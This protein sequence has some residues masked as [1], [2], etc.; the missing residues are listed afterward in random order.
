M[1]INYVP[2][3]QQSIDN[4]LKVKTKLSILEIFIRIT[5]A[6]KYF[7]IYS[8]FGWCLLNAAYNRKLFAHADSVRIESHQNVWCLTRP[9]TMYAFLK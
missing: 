1:I 2:K 8:P 6:Y 4:Q 7:K 3:Y 5:S 9:D